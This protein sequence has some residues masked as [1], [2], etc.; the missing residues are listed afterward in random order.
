MSGRALPLPQQKGLDGLGGFGFQVLAGT[1]QTETTRGK[2]CE[3][4]VPEKLAMTLLK[5]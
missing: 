4:K 2:S 1:R 3:N 5:P